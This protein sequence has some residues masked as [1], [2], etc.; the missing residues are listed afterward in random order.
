MLLSDLGETKW[1]Q[2][3]WGET[4]PRQALPAEREGIRSPGPRLGKAAD[5]GW[6]LC[7]PGA[8]EKVQLR[9]PNRLNAPEGLGS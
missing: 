3:E 8:G 2:V 7:V 5:K 6:K 1:D 9:L 4:E